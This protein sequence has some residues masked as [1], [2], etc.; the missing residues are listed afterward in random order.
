MKLRILALAALFVLPAGIALA[1]G[2][3]Q[4]LMT[5]ADKV[6]LENTARRAR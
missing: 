5:P 4:K 2:V 6:R 1:D 3:V